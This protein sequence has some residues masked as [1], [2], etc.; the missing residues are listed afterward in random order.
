MSDL[1][2]A[3]NCGTLRNE[4]SKRLHV[5]EERMNLTS[6]KDDSRPFDTGEKDE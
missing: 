1:T 4:T 3:Q 6:K 5:M 2:L